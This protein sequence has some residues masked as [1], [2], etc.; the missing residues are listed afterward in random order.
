MNQSSFVL[1]VLAVALK[2]RSL[3]VNLLSN[4]IQLLDFNAILRIESGSFYHLGRTAQ[5]ALRLHIKSND[6]SNSFEHYVPWGESA[7]AL[8]RFDHGELSMVHFSL[9][10]MQAL[11]N[12]IHSIGADYI[13][14]ELLA[15]VTHIEGATPKVMPQA[16]KGVFTIIDAAAK[17]I[18]FNYDQ[19]A[20]LIGKLPVTKEDKSG[21]NPVAPAVEETIDDHVSFGEAILR[22][23][24]THF[25]ILSGFDDDD[26]DE[27]EDADDA[28]AAAL[29]S[30]A[31][32]RASILDALQSNFPKHMQFTELMDFVAASTAME[33]GVWVPDAWA[34]VVRDILAELPPAVTHALVVMLVCGYDSDEFL[35]VCVEKNGDE[36]SDLA[37]RLNWLRRQLNT[38]P[39]PHVKSVLSD[40][41]LREEFVCHVVKELPSG[42]ATRR[43]IELSR[44][45]RKRTTPRTAPTSASPAQRGRPVELK[46]PKSEYPVYFKSHA[47]VRMQR[48]EVRILDV[49]RAVFSHFDRDVSVFGFEDGNSFCNA[50]MEEAGVGLV[51]IAHMVDMA[52]SLC[53][54]RDW[55]RDD[56]YEVLTQVPIIVPSTLYVASLLGLKLEALHEFGSTLKT[57]L[58]STTVLASFLLTSNGIFHDI[59][60]RRAMC[61]PMQTDLYKKMQASV[62]YDF[63]ND[64]WEAKDAK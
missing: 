15:Y 31:I 55:E 9:A 29:E 18:L 25:E 23:L 41:T 56:L 45:I 63:S 1:N 10:D 34:P 28:D 5:K 59:E 4:S 62:F 19:K 8:G 7:T 44:W 51:G 46:L 22:E 42:D 14:N 26:Y 40:D 53:D 38:Q 64:I 17:G 30:I 32:V 11:A 27:Y 2:A 12:A 35:E 61:A 54:V 20:Y 24:E 60:V 48:R 57:E 16:E 36:I 21:E 47:N 33:D 13:P 39:A 3:N 49:A 58:P 6:T 52:M 50:V 37:T 43:P